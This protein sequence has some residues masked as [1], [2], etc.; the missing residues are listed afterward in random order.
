MID[1]MIDMRKVFQN[2]YFYLSV[3]GYLGCIH[4]ITAFNS[5]SKS[6]FY[7]VFFVVLFIKYHSLKGFAT[8]SPAF[9]YI[10]QYI[11]MCN[12]LIGTQVEL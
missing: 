4:I 9:L 12:I 10:Y 7:D 3:V 6:M 11:S 8:P 2:M 1:T 5:K